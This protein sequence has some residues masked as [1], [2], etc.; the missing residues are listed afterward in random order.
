MKRLVTALMIL[1]LA[2]CAARGSAPNTA[3]L[4]SRDF[5]GHLTAMEREFWFRPCGAGDTERWW[6]TFTGASIR[7]LQDARTEKTEDVVK[8]NADP[9]H[10]VRQVEQKAVL[11]V[12]AGQPEILV[13]DGDALFHLVECDLQKVAVVLQRLGR[14]IEQAESIL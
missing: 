1:P 10:L 12:P 6:V 8:R 9:A 7:K 11:P 3:D 2:A 4:P 13:E 14:V 5:A